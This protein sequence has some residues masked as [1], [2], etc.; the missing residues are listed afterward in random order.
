MWR[1]LKRDIEGRMRWI[2]DVDLDAVI[3]EA[4][5]MM[6]KGAKQGGRGVLV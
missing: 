6:G 3:A 1:G 4:M 5:G 2:W